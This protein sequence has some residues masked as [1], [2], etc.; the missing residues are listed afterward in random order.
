MVRR[1]FGLWVLM[2]VGVGVALA[3]HET[4]T[5]TDTPPGGAIL[6]RCNGYPGNCVAKAEMWEFPYNITEARLCGGL[7]QSKFC[8]TDTRGNV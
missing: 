2:L 5:T 6:A 1:V 7:H 8:H 4:G 3:L